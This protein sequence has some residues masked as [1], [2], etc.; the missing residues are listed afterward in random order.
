MLQKKIK[1]YDKILILIIL[2]LFLIIR[3]DLLV[4][5]TLLL[6]TP[7]LL[8]TKRSILFKHLLI[9]FLVAF[10]WTILSKDHYAY[11]ISMLSI[12]GIQLFPL[13]AW[14]LGLLAVYM[15]YSH[16]EHLIKKATI[17]KKT[18]LFTL[19]YWPLLLITETLG[20]HL[21]EIE[22]MGEVYAGLPICN[23]MHG[24]WWLQLSYFSMGII[25]FIICILLKLENP[26]TRN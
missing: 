14:T 8:L 3:P 4:I 13:F 5:F 1:Y 18:I 11:N 12:G 15:L 19:I 25:F 22:N 6:I 20:R 24:P 16:Y 10:T 9:S 7:Y 2:S 23:C 17:P 21:F 26:H